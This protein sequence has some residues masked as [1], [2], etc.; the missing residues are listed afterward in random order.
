ML[1]LINVDQMVT[2]SKLLSK[3]PSPYTLM[4]PHHMDPQHHGPA[5][6]LKMDF[7]RESEGTTTPF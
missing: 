6:L 3:R 7:W 2:A 1:E 5:S 4:H